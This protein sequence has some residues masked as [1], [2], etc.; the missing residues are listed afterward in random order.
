MNKLIEIFTQFLKRSI[1]PSS[2]FVILLTI[3]FYDKINELLKNFSFIADKPM[4]L[5]IVSGFF[6][7]S[8]SYIITIINQIIFDNTIKKNFNSLF[9][10]PSDNKL[11]NKLRNKSI[12]KLKKETSEFN[13]IDLN[14]FTLYQIIG[15]KLQFFKH[16]TNTSRYIDEIKS[17]ESI[18]TSIALILIIYLFFIKL[19]IWYF[20][21]IV[22]LYFLFRSYI[23]S[24]FR[25]RNIRMYINYLIGDLSK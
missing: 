24:K 13:D 1:L 7:I 21:L 17:A 23:V 25:F 11:L 15:R 3:I 5:S 6:L 8:I 4:Y 12:E 9:L 18:Y 10:Y 2:T 16:K 14:D 19:N 20:L 22:I